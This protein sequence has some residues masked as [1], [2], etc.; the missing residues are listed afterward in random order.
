MIGRPSRQN[1]QVL[2]TTSMLP[3]RDLIAV[4][5][6]SSLYNEG[7]RRGVF[8]AESWLLVHMMLHGQPERRLAFAGYIRDLSAGKPEAC[9]AIRQSSTENCGVT[10]DQSRST[11]SAWSSTN[12]AS[13][14]AS[15]ALP[16][17]DA[18]AAGTSPT[19]SRA[20]NG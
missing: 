4:T 10:F 8:Y 15:R 9:S 14:S 2:Q 1:L 19:C 11:P 13:G 12:A 16:L 18:D 5:R 6:D 7:D 3:V 20:S 17:S